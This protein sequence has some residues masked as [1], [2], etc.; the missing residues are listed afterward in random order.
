VL[1]VGSAAAS[2]IRQDRF[3][4]FAAAMDGLFWPLRNDDANS[5]IFPAILTSARCAAEMVV[6]GAIGTAFAVID[7]P[8]GDALN[9][10][11]PA[12]GDSDVTSGDDNGCCDRGM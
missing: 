12:N 6:S 1:P 4:S 8:A 5:L 10:S 9:A 3:L 11:A 2:P 7:R